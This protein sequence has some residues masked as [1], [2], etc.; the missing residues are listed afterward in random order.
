M[1]K[2]YTNEI[3]INPMKDFDFKR[4]LRDNKEYVA[5]FISLICN[6]DYKVV[7]KGDFI[8]PNL[9]G[10]KKGTVPRIGDLV[11]KIDD[12]TYVDI[13]AYTKYSKITNLKSL[14]YS[15]RMASIYGIKID[16][17]GKKKYN[18]NIKIYSISIYKESNKGNLDLI[19]HDTTYGTDFN[20]YQFIETYHIYLD[21]LKTNRY[22]ESERKIYDYLYPLVPKTLEDM[23]SILESNGIV[24]KD[25]ILRGVYQSM[26]MFYKADGSW[27]RDA[28]N[29]HMLE[30][31]YAEG[32][33]YGEEVGEE[34]GKKQGIAI[35]KKRGI[36]IG[37]KQ[38]LKNAIK[39]LS[40]NGM[41]NHE[42]A[43][44]LNINLEDVEEILNKKRLKLNRKVH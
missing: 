24:Q 40:K 33:G 43:N 9:P 14:D 35:G 37:E 8:D 32:Y 38:C 15:N 36:S 10:A 4:V 17:N 2:L 16:K 6:L 26:V 29:R 42:I 34:R 23:E 22:T 1:N 5:M 31:E 44:G 39:S 19:K 7:V 21:K 27:D 30:E 3:K 28:Y 12:D 18:V 13:E 11:Y 20:K 41:I 25:K